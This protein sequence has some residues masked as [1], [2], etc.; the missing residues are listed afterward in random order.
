MWAEGAELFNVNVPLQRPA[1]PM[2]PPQPHAGLAHS[3]RATGRGALRCGTTVT[4]T[5]VD[6]RSSYGSLYGA[7]LARSCSLCVLNSADARG[8]SPDACLL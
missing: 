6:L 8:L 3:V 7:V 5:H 4:L 2:L 1:A